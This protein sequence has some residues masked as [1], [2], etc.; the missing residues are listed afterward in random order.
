VTAYSGPRL[1]S[2]SF[3]VFGLDRRHCVRLV[4]LHLFGPGLPATGC[5]YSASTGVWGAPLQLP[6][7]SSGDMRARPAPESRAYSPP[8]GVTCMHYRGS[9]RFVRPAPAEPHVYSTPHGV[10]YVRH[11]GLL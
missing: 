2:P 5:G 3:S 6:C 8:H 4:L 11:A 9:T 7:D 10:A 1:P